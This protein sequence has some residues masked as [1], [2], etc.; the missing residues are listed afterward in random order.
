VLG[1][2]LEFSI[3]TADIRASI[4]FY[5]RLGFEQAQT[6]DVW[7]HPYAVLTDGRMTLGLH[8]D[9][10]RELAL[11]FVHPEVAERGA[12]L[13]R[14][15]LELTYRRTGAESF[16][17]IGLDDPSGQRIRIV[18]ARTYSPAPRA[19]TV[20]S[21]CGY[22]AELSLPATDFESAARFWEP[23]GF[24]ATELAEPYPRLLLTSDLL[25][26]AFHAPRMLADPALVF[27]DQ[28]MRERIAQLHDLGVPSKRKLPAGLDPAA[29]A[30]LQG[31]EGTVLLLLTEQP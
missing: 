30:L 31:P 6:R 1:R 8:Q 15:G 28:N 4:E 16:H 18:E 2:F 29:D 22:F 21:L 14:Q 13:E 27:T 12:A 25:N 10:A 3:P 5:E 26:L 11:T 19:P 24:V 20:T 17:E 7:S 23:L 9:P